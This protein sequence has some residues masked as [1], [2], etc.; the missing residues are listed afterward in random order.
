IAAGV[1]LVEKLP[2]RVSVRALVAIAC[3]AG[4]G[5]QHLPRALA[6]L[7]G[8]EELRAL[9]E[10]ASSRYRSPARLLAYNTHAYVAR[11]S[12][13]L[14]TTTLLES[15]E[16]FAEA[17]ELERAGM[18]CPVELTPDLAADLDSRPRPF[19]LVLPRARA[20]LVAGARLTPLAQTP[21]YL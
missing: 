5:L 13:T 18:P 2:A 9:A 20:S 4:A 1:L 11:Y 8:E 3:V 10:L 16:D 17:K 6:G 7:R 12:A 14:D 15:A 19:A 21:R